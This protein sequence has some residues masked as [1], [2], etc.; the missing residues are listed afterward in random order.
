VGGS[1]KEQVGAFF[2]SGL[3][4]VFCDSLEV[5]ADIFWTDTFLADFRRLRGYDLTPFLPVVKE[6]GGY[7]GQPFYDF[8]GGG[9][10]VRHDYWQTVSDVM[11]ANFYQ[12]FADWA[13]RNNLQVRVQ[14]HG[15]P[16]DVLKA[17]GLSHIPETEDL[18]S[19]GRYDFLKYAASAAHV[20]G[21]KLT[22]SETFVAMGNPYV[23]TPEFIKRRADEMLTAGINQIVYSGFPYEYMDRAEPGWYPFSAPLPYSTNLSPHNPFWEYVKPLN[24]Y[25]SRLQY[26]SQTG[27][28]VA[29]VALFR[30]NLA[31]KSVSPPPSGLDINSGLMG[32]GYNFDHINADALLKSRAESG[33]LI[34]PGGASYGC[35]ILLNE[36]RVALE[37][38][39]KLAGFARSGV[40]VL[41]IGS[42]P[43]EEI[44]FR[45]YAQRS[46]RI[47][48]L[49]KD[50][51]LKTTEEAIAALRLRIPPN[52]QFTK[53]APW[54]Y[55]FQKKLGPLD[56]Y[57]LRNSSADAHRVGVNFP[58]LSSPEIWDPW[59]GGISPALEFEAQ[60]DGLRMEFDL[61]PYGS[62]LI[63][64]D[65]A[66]KHAA[67]APKPRPQGEPVNIGG[68]WLLEA[69]GRQLELSDLVDWSQHPQLRS[70]SGKA[71]YT[72][73]FFL[74]KVSPMELDLGEVKDVA[75]IRLNEKSGPTLLLRPY[76]AEVTGLLQPGENVLEVTVTNALTNRL[77]AA[78]A[79]LTGLFGIGKKLA[80]QPSGLIGPVRLLPR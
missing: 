35:L 18:Y 22:S 38:A 57:F 64:F 24:A 21:R 75:E 58:A 51:P 2:G 39:E 76:R 27:T 79:D 52:L 6:F 56:V 29:P 8:D 44:G 73:R 72:I 42:V 53:P 68:K 48:A 7:R 60:A 33:R 70:F 59:T 74:P 28:N 46:L 80:P 23:T 11:I 71:R 34:S 30:S 69:A 5:A 54:A 77:L 14:A 17:Y 9:S 31:Y 43:R 66:R 15:A 10:R 32:A 47:Q 25:I 19:G 37:L 63:V 16:A 41:Y 67:Q 26:L 45:D 78:G 62:R 20:Y 49:L 1:A 36:E 50:T 13:E 4:A 65:P 55:F 40:P 3:R 61:G 12:P